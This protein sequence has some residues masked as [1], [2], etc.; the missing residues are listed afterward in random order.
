MKKLTVTT[1]IAIAGLL[2]LSANSFSR[3]DDD[4]FGFGFGF[5]SAPPPGLTSVNINL[6]V[7]GQGGTNTCTNGVTTVHFKQSKL[8]NDDMLSL[9]NDEFGTSFSRTN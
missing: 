8:D 7:L 3:G 6:F 2:T 9:I 4:G 1:V 5:K